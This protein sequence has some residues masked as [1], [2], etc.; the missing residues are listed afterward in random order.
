VAAEAFRGG[1]SRPNILNAAV[2]TGQDIG[3]QTSMNQQ[4]T[5][6]R[7]AGDVGTN[8]AMGAGLAATPQLAREV[9][10]GV[11]KAA[12]AVD[13]SVRTANAK[14]GTVADYDAHINDLRAQ[15]AALQQRIQRTPN[16]RGVETT[17]RHIDQLD[18]E[19]A[20][21]CSQQTK[22]QY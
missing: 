18:S 22:A 11:K 3:H 4:I 9:A 14:K 20:R 16:F 15:Q 17:Q 21:G 6:L 12:R 7:I 1:V 13:T 2:G 8:L 5:P 10:P 19:I